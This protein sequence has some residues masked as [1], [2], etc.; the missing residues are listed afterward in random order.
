MVQILYEVTNQKDSHSERAAALGAFIGAAKWDAIGGSA[1]RRGIHTL[2]FWGHGSILTLCGKNADAIVEIIKSWKALNPDLKTVEVI[3]CNSR[4]GALDALPFIGKIKAGMRRGIRSSTH[5][6]K[7]KSLP[8]NVNGA[9]GGF[10]ILLA[11]ASTKTWCYITSSGDKDTTMMYARGEMDRMASDAKKAGTPV[12]LATLA[13][14][15]IKVT[16]RKDPDGQYF[17]MNYGHFNTLRDSL[18]LVH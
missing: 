13:E 2:I 10:S 18:S 5:D 14:E 15:V 12:D 16:G 8:V 6:V 7:L 11:E 1:V 17:T 9:L 4:H 3:T